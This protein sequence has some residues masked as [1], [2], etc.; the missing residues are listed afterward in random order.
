[1]QAYLYD[2]AISFAGEQRH[3][4]LSI[5]SRLDASGY[6]IFYDGFEAAQLWGSELPVK[7][8]EIYEK[9][10]RF[11]LILA[12]HEY[13]NKM[14]TNVERRFAISRAIS[15][16]T[17]YVLPIKIDDSTLPGLPPTIG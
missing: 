2:L 10:A 11:C 4:A 5:S 1:M 3:L 6:S 15:V 17:D 13:V 14:W 8:G 12:S 16:N 7:L 9:Q